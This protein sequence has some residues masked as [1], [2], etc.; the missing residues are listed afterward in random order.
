MFRTEN[1]LSSFLG[2]LGKKMK[3]SEIDDLYQRLGVRR[4]ASPDE[5]K[6][7]YR[8]A[9]LKWHPDSSSKLTDNVREAQREFVA[10]SEAYQVLSD[11]ERR[12]QYDRQTAVA[13]PT[14]KPQTETKKPE[15]RPS[16]KPDYDF[17]DI[18]KDK[19]DRYSNFYKEHI[20]DYIIPIMDDPIIT[21]DARTLYDIL[22]N[23]N[24]K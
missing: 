2:N 8:T 10:I 24:K 13:R 20:E 3:P 19:F 23:A 14:A 21:N 17:N 18:I 16:K 1:A 4:D 11:L 22:K 12:T 15:R 7:A 5:L 9:A 6:K